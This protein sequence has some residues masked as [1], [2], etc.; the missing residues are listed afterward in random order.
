MCDCDQVVDKFGGVSHVMVITY[1]AL[2]GA[3]PYY[4][5]FLTRKKF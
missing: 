2:L 1:W 3:L 5:I 4:T